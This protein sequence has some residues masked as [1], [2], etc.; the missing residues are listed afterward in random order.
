MKNK[1]V[2]ANADA[3]DWATTS[4]LLD[5]VWRAKKDLAEMFYM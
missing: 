1:L 3:K 4:A 5:I 2:G